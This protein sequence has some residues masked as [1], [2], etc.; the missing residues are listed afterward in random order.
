MGMTFYV[1]AMCYIRIKCNNAL[2][3][4]WQ[5]IFIPE[6]CQPLTPTVKAILTN[7]N[8]MPADPAGY[9]SHKEVCCP[10]KDVRRF[11]IYNNVSLQSTFD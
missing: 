3:S 9:L 11:Y 1:S 8:T 5:T 2:S 6:L 7:S 4:N 10:C